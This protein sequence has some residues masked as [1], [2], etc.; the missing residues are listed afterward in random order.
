MLADA[1]DALAQSHDAI[2]AA[3]VRDA[4]RLARKAARARV[5]RIFVLYFLSALCA[6]ICAARAL[7]RLEHAYASG[8]FAF[9][10][11]L[12]RKVVGKVA[13]ASKTA[14]A[15]PWL[16]TT[17]L[18]ATRAL[19]TIKALV[20]ANS[21]CVIEVM[22][23]IVA[24][25]AASAL[26]RALERAEEA[27]QRI[28]AGN[29]D[30]E[31]QTTHANTAGGIWS[32]LKRGDESAVR[33]LTIESDGK[34]LRERGPVGETPLHLMLLYGG[35]LN[36]GDSAHL[37]SAKMIGER[38]P[39]IVNDVY[40]GDE[41]F[42]ESCLHIAIVNKNR[43]LVEL[44]LKATPDTPGLLAA[45]ATGRFFTRGQ[46][47]YYGEYALSFAV[48]TG[49][50]D[51]VEILL[52]CGADATAR[53]LHGNTCLH[54]AVIHNQPEMFVLVCER[55]QK[56]AVKKE[57]ANDEISLEDIVNADGLSPMLFAA[58]SGYEDMFNFQL[59]R[60]CV[61]EWSYGP[62]MCQRM[63]LLDIDTKQREG[64][65]AL[66]HIV[67]RGHMNL[68]CLPLIQELLQRKWDV[69]IGKLFY[70]RIVQILLFLIT[71]TAVHVTSLADSVE[72]FGLSSTVSH[73]AKTGILTVVIAQ[74]MYEYR[75][76][77]DAS[78]QSVVSVIFCC[79]Y[80][81]SVASRTFIEHELAADSFL[82]FAFLSA[83]FYFIWLFMGFKSTGHFVIMV[84]EIIIDDVSPFGLIL[85]LF[86]V[87]FSTAIFVVLQPVSNRSVAMFGDQLL[88]CFEWLTGGG[89]EGDV[90]ENA[91]RGK[92]LMIILLASFTILGA[93]VLLN[94]LVAMMGD[95]YAKV[96]ENAVAKWQLER[97]RIMLSLERGI[98]RA[99]RDRLANSVWIELDGERFLQV[100]LVDG[101]TALEHATDD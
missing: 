34:C 27:L 14:A 71:M 97:A 101:K 40:V 90:V 20:L 61:T 49:Q 22:S 100:Q 52:E 16:G 95:T 63:P 42:G 74:L 9:K 62:V 31:L 82:A 11:I 24:A 70:T 94:L 81:A 46:P 59:G 73:T 17:N 8:S 69:Y 77:A 83:W 92:V 35:G 48:S 98:P 29:R 80:L 66:E 54:L 96:S 55:W 26:L 36:I 41:Y 3:N 30:V 12:A 72:Q 45:R 79:T 15:K 28:G 60:L 89:F 5:R 43:A 57:D 50:G 10:S 88:T 85:G 53:D 6:L 21:T 7:A 13:K 39:D 47:C 99:R 78:G 56:R 75:H 4:R 23:A 37:R 51:L 33:A 1:P 76:R 87:A 38:W 68:L 19:K 67:E 93:I 58:R 25:V 65:S 86:V 44:L 32:A 18:D 2:N 64:R 84:Y 91:P